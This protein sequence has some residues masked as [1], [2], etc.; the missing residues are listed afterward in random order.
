[1]TR[2]LALC[3][4]A[5]ALLASGCGG[6]DETSKAEYEKQVREAGRTLE[7]TFAG[8]GT[9]ISDA[10]SAEDAAIKLE[11]GAAALQEASRKLGAIEPP[12]DIRDAHEDV[13]DGLASLSEEFR[14]GAKAAEGGDVSKLLEFATRLQASPAVKKIEAAGKVI[15]EKGYEF[16]P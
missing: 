13:V 1:M 2:A 7:S 9:A 8:I 5:L 6:G 12:S 14:A 11:E 10:D 16:E 15:E 4:A 3:G